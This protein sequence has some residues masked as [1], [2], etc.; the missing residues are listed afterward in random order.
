[1]IRAA[2]FATLFATAC[3]SAS[4]ASCDDL[5]GAWRAEATGARWMILDHGRSLEGYPLFDDGKPTSVSPA[6]ETAPR[7]IDLARADGELRG[8]VK[9]RFMRGADACVGKLPV[10]VTACTGDTLELVFAEPVPPLTFAPCTWG[11]T[12]PSRRERW[13]R[14]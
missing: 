8:E 11:T 13:L 1:V 6:L 12:G 5:R 3:S 14:E 10:R 2:L 7:V 9:R 4:S